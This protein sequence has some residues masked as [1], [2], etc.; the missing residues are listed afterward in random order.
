VHELSIAIEAHHV[1]VGAG[2][3]IF[4]MAR[5]DFKVN[6]KLRA[7]VLQVMTVAAAVRKG[8]AITSPEQTLS[9]VLDER[10]FTFQDKDKLVFMAVPVSLT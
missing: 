8:G 1:D 2:C 6:G 5:A 10:E 7:P 4:S 3:Q 9:L